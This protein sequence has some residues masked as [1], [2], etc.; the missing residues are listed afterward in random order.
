MKSNIFREVLD[1]E[2]IEV[3]KSVFK[4]IEYLCELSSS[5]KKDLPADTYI[6]FLCSKKGN[7]IV[8][9]TYRQSHVPHFYNRHR[10]FENMYPL[11]CVYGK[12][13]SKDNKTYI[14]MNSV[15]KK[16]NLFLRYFLKTIG[17]TI[18]PLYLLMSIPFHVFIFN[19]PLFL[20]AVAIALVVFLDADTPLAAQKS[21]GLTMLPYMENEIKIRVKNI[22]QWED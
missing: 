7:I 10:T 1:E 5:S 22:E 4:T 21:R 13:L 12:V 2:Y 17:I 9:Y 20:I 6:H 16:Y 15:Y 19:F 8:R 14:K 3:N 18:I 11:Y